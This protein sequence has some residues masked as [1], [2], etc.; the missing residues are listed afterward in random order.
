MKGETDNHFLNQTSQMFSV[1]MKHKRDTIEI[2]TQGT[3]TDKY[4]YRHI[5]H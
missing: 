1:F 2:K 3:D 4:K 5:R